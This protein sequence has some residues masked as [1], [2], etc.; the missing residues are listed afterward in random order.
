MFF[1]RKGKLRKSFNEQ[2]IESLEKNKNEWMR[3]KEIV[4]RCVEP[5][6]EVLYHLKLAEAKYLFL[7]RE[8]KKRKVTLLR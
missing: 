7:I 1:Q 8:A 5:S 6:A 2:L 3:Q 4:N